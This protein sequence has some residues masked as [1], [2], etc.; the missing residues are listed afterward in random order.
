MTSKRVMRLKVQCKHYKEECEWRGELGDLDEHLAHC[1][2]RKLKC[3]YGCPVNI[4]FCDLEVH[5][6]DECI[7][8]PPEKKADTNSR[9]IAEL[10]QDIEWLKQ[11]V[12]QCPELT[13]ENRQLSTHNDTKLIDEVTQVKDRQTMFDHKIQEQCKLYDAKLTD[14]VANIEHKVQEQAT[15]QTKFEIQL[16]KLLDEMASFEHKLQ[17]Q[18]IRC[19]KK[20]P[21]TQRNVLLIVLAVLFIGGLIAL[22]SKFLSITFVATVYCLFSACYCFFLP[23]V[24][25]LDLFQHI[26]KN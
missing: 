14:A 6:S 1:Q 13:L 3:P 12:L 18:G 11:C 19:D 4:S 25:V 15:K 26:F 17:A 21:S 24:R 8:R 5:K 2:Y 22:Y 10:R 23:I 20:I 16:Q 9:K 7:L